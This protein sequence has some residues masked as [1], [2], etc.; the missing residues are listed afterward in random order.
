M[1]STQLT[2]HLVLTVLSDYFKV[3]MSKSTERSSRAVTICLHVV[4]FCRLVNFRMKLLFGSCVAI[5]TQISVV[6]SRR[7]TPF[8]SVFRVRTWSRT[9]LER[10]LQ[11]Y[12]N[13]KVHKFCVVNSTIPIFKFFR[14]SPTIS[15]IMVLGACIALPT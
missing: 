13:F 12:T 8:F 7:I 3:P 6:A 4:T 5:L 2:A 9:M 14:T 15:A 1:F 10:E 11:I